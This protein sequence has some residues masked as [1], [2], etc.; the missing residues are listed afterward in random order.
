MSPICSPAQSLLVCVQGVNE[1]W[2]M[3]REGTLLVEEDP[4]S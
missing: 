1:L 2:D 3:C 4:P